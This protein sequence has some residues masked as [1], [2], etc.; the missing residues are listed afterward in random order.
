MHIQLD[1]KVVVITGSTAGIGKEVAKIVA[2]EGAITI[3]N[4]RSSK[5]VAATVQELKEKTGSFTIY[6]VAAD[7]SSPEGIA[8]FILQVAD[9]NLPPVYALVNNTGIF[10]SKP[11]TE[12]GD[13][14]WTTFF[15]TNVLSGVKLSKAFLPTMLDRDEGTI[16]FVSS[17]AALAPKGFMIHYSMTKAAQL[18]ISRGLAELTKGT[19]VRINSILPGPTMTEGVEKYM[20][21]MNDH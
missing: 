16:L 10:E 18:S 21:G 11:F 12:I 8:S 1:G 19:K 5:T 7:V 17:E 9:L 14:E 6:G 13:D 4:G 20:Q 3:V 15:E 2:S